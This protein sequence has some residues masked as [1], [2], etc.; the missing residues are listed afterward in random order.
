MKGKALDI[1]QD[2]TRRVTTKALVN[3][4]ILTAIS[5][6]LSRALGIVV[7]IVG[8]PALKINFSTVPIMLT[9]IY[10]GPVMGLMSGA[11]SDIIGYMINP[12]GGAYFP[13]FTLTTALFGFIPG[14]IYRFIRSTKSRYDF[15]ILNGLL[16]AILAT[17]IVYVLFTKDILS[18][19]NWGIYYQNEKMSIAYLLI[20]IIL[21][22]AYILLPILL[23]TIK[24]R[25]RQDAYSIDKIFFTVSLA[26]LIASVI[27]NTWFLSILF[28]KAFYIFLPARI[29]NAFIVIP[30]HSLI[31]FSLTKT[32]Q[33]L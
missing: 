9:G 11:V 26:Q 30:I 12:L 25:N 14:I 31:I 20:F 8:F 5:I 1:S 7:P 15:Y 19:R 17:G 29:L 27:M 10:W 32:I 6:I 33:I 3:T 13:G 2:S 24:G 22:I 21:I 18:V 4:G 28:S 23:S 16:T